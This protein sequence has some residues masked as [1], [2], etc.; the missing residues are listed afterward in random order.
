IVNIDADINLSFC[1]PADLT[2]AGNTGVGNFAQIGHG[3]QGFNGSTTGDISTTGTVL[4]ATIAGGDGSLGYAQLG[5]GGF[6]AN[7][8]KGGDITLVAETVT[9]SGG[10]GGNSSGKIGHGG[11]SGTGQVSGGISVT[12]TVGDISASAGS[13]AG[14]WTQLGHGGNNFVGSVTAQPITVNSANNVI[15][16]GGGGAL[17]W[18]MIGH[19]G[20]SAQGTEFSGDVDVTSGN[21]I[22]VIGGVGAGSY[23]QIGS[24]GSFAD[25]SIGG[26]ITVDAGRNVTMT[27]PNQTGGAYSQIGNGDNFNGG[28]APLS[29]S[30]AREGD[31]EVSAGSDITLTKSFI[32]HVN[33]ENTNAGPAS[34]TT[35]IG[36]AR[37]NPEDP[38]AGSVRTDGP[39]SGFAGPDGLYFYM[40]RRE[41]NQVAPGTILN[42]WT[43]WAG[44]QSDPSPTQLPDE[45]TRNIIGETI[46]FPREHEN[47]FGTGPA[48]HIDTAGYAFNFD[49]IEL[50]ALPPAPP[51]ATLL[52]TLFPDDRTTDDWQREQEAIYTGFNPWEVYYEGFVQY[53]S[54]GD[55]IFSTEFGNTLELDSGFTEDVLE[56]Q[57][58][59][60]E[61]EQEEEEEENEE[62]GAE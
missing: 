27:A 7:R 13:G 34:G 5:H 46:L 57:I 45:F 53:D 40:P 52:D 47:Q 30:G 6:Q 36:P 59:I 4:D 12:S 21:D 23:A 31:I 42:G 60:L 15:V 32:G 29:G 51:A 25:A 22:G 2:I 48:P 58:R 33:G 56:R 54:S 28:F 19:G 43:G 1:E 26:D 18:S 61:E 44:G 38:A 50:V 3:G 9:I 37:D 17:A 20:L 62:E 14:A 16:R 55:S 11:A 35:S 49:T 24:G 39:E 8:E 10:A 41:N